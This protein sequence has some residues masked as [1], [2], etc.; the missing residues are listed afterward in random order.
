[1]GSVLSFSCS[2]SECPHLIQSTQRAGLGN[3]ERSGQVPKV[4]MPEQKR[5]LWDGWK[6]STLCQRKVPKDLFWELQTQSKAIPAEGKNISAPVTQ[7]VDEF[8]SVN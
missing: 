2:R 1:M 8:K 6:M 3:T 7:R 5:E 4:K